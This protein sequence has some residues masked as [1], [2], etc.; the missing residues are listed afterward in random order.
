M[1]GMIQVQ[2]LSGMLHY[3]QDFPQK[4]KGANDA[5]WI[6]LVFLLHLWGSFFFRFAYLSLFFPR[7]RMLARM[8]NRHKEFVMGIL[9][10]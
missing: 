10:S 3:P 4:R 5:F 6:A 2:C 1:I 9:K 8:G 7:L